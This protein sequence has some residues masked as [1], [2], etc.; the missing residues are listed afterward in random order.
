VEHYKVLAIKGDGS[1][2]YRAV[3]VTRL[4]C[5]DLL[6]DG[7]SAAKRGGQ[8]NCNDTLIHCLLQA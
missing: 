8:L 7:E 1:C 4:S 2:L 5:V 6:Q 3:S